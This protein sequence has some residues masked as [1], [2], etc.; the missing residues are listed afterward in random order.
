[1]RIIKIDTDDIVLGTDTVNSAV[2]HSA[3]TLKVTGCCRYYNTIFVILEETEESYRYI[4]A[5]LPAASEDELT[6]LLRSRFD[7]GF[8]T[9]TNF[10]INDDCWALFEK[11]L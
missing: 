7:S 5:P 10:Y 2:E 4:F 6:A 3:Y 1:M 8:S 9:I 11:K